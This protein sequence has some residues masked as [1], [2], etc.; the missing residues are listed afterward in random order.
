MS[1]NLFGITGPPGSGKADLMVDLV[2]EL[3]R[4]GLRVSTI[5]SV[6]EQA[7]IDQP[8]KDSFRH[9][10]AGADEVLVTSAQRW[11]LIHDGGAKDYHSQA[12]MTAVDIILVAQRDGAGNFPM[13]ELRRAGTAAALDQDDPAVVAVVS[14]QPLDDLQKPLLDRDDLPAIADFIIAYMDQAGGA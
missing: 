13:I 6:D 9:R 3:S 2:S 4:R 14:D 7:A 1:D 11:A 12:Q 10:A 8:G 5:L